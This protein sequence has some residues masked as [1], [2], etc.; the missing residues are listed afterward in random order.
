MRVDRDPVEVLC[1]GVHL[2]IEAGVREKRE[3]HDEIF[4]PRSIVRELKTTSTDC[5]QVPANAFGFLI[6]WVYCVNNHSQLRLDL[7]D[8]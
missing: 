3:L 5:W 8:L 4:P 2:V 7:R 1:G 6:N